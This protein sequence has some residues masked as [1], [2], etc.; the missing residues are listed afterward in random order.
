LTLR[1]FS[2]DEKL[3]AVVSEIREAQRADRPPGSSAQRHFEVLKSIAAD[4]RA[5]QELPRSNTLGELARLLEKMKAEDR[6]ER[7]YDHNRMLAVANHVIGRWPTISQ[8]LEQ[9]GEESA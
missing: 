3:D 8:A 9:F 2:I 7:G 4:L 6:P 1:L 5:R